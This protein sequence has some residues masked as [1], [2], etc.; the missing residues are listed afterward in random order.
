MKILHVIPSISPIRG[1]TSRAILDMV[2]AL[3]TV[4][5]DAEIVTTNDNGRN[6]LPVAV[7]QLLEYEQVPVRFFSRLSSD[8][9][10]L[11]EFNFSDS[12][13]KWLWQN[14]D[15]Y[16]LVH[17]HALFS[18]PSTIAMLIARIKNVPYI[19]IPHGL[20]CEWSLQQ[21]TRKKQ[22]FM[23]LVE[24]RNLTRSS[25]LHLTSLKE[26]KEVTDLR[27]ST[28]SFV[29]P[30][31]LDMPLSVSNASQCLRQSLNIKDDAPIVLFMGRIHHK[32]GLDYLIPALAQIKRIPFHFV[33]AGSGD[34]E[35]E[36]EV[37]A[38][39]ASEGMQ[40]RTHRT[41]FVEGEYKDIILQGS[42]IFAL[43]SH[44]ENF[45]VAV[46]E[47]LAAGL[48]A[49]LTPGV[50]LSDVVAQHQLGKVIA[51]HQDEISMAISQL[52]LD[53][54]AIQLTG[55]RARQF[56]LERYTWKKIATNLSENYQSILEKKPLSQYA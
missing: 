20:L 27:L 36:V 47:A 49:V 56:I 9:S 16:N 48:P 1:G 21:S 51:L 23:M 44:S 19:A 22:L 46:L 13:T 30:L 33:L 52:L 45:G 50:A 55:D 14:I 53:R 54:N 26:Q 6:T 3:R 43:T 29:L 7:K 12:L 31:G 25:A 24:R 38:L 5:V 15:D 2:L 32:K 18:Y 41:G 42:D 11:Q 8:V 28:N 39:I 4:N 34:P 35:Y 37:D 40:N 10:A 17:V